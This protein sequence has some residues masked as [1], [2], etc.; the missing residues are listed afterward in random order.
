MPIP[1]PT[2]GQ[3][4]K[5]QFSNPTIHEGEFV[6]FNIY[7]QEIEKR[8]FFNDAQKQL[9]NLQQ[10]ELPAGIYFYVK[11]AKGTNKIVESGKLIA[12]GR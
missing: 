10:N 6:I 3:S 1:L 9:W 8:Y 4:S 5:I 12:I 7:G 11:R 2:T